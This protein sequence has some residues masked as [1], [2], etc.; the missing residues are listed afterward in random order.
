DRW[1]PGE[2]AAR[3]RLDRFVEEAVSEYSGHRDRPDRHG[4]SRLSPHLHFGEISP[5]QVALALEA[6]GELPAGQGRLS[7]LREIAWREF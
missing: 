6:S 3:R 7:Y 4:T 1:E 5:A 2:L